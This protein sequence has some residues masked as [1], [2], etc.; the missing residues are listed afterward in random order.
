MWS[1][2]QELLDN[3]SHIELLTLDFFDTL[4]TR[5]VAQPTH[6]FAEVERML[7][8]EHGSR[9]RGYGLQRVRAEQ[10]AR[11]TAVDDDKY[12]DVTHDEVMKELA[13]GMK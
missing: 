4:V 11:M 2:A 1:T 6:V 9:W 8:Q 13:L 5:N 3:H 10:R 12:L 7:V